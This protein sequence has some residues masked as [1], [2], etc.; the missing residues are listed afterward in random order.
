MG[1]TELINTAGS[2]LSLRDCYWPC[3][4]SHTDVDGDHIISHTH[5]C[6][7]RV[8]DQEGNG[9]ITPEHSPTIMSSLVMQ[10]LTRL[11]NRPS[12]ICL[13]TTMCWQRKI[14]NSDV[15]S[16]SRMPL[17]AIRPTTTFCEQLRCILTPSKTWPRP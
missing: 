3:G 2:H 9:Y 8:N 17:G 13:I 7:L 5:S 11:A 16:N 10:C 6:Y 4:V 14:R 1:A 15:S 12:I